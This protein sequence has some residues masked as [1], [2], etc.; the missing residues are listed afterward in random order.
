MVGGSE[1]VNQLCTDF[2]NDTLRAVG[3]DAPEKAIIANAAGWARIRFEQESQARE[4][5]EAWPLLTSRF[6]PGIQIIQTLHEMKGTLPEALDEGFEALRAARNLNRVE[7]PE[8]GPLVERSQRTG[9]AAVKVEKERDVKVLVDRST[10]RKRVCAAGHSSLVQKISQ[11]INK[12]AWPYEIDD[13][14]S[15]KSPYIAVI[16]AD[17]NDLGAT[18]MRIKEFLK[19]SPDDAAK[20]YRGFSAAI[21]ETTVAAVRDACEA[22]VFSAYRK[23]VEKNPK[24]KIAARPIVLGGDDL[25]IIIRADRA[26]E[27]TEKFLEAFEKSSKDILD[28]HLGFFKIEGRPEYLT[29]CA[30]IAFVKK[31][32][33]FSAAYHMAETLC[34][35]TKRVAKAARHEAGGTY[36]PSS[37][38]FHRITTSMAESFSTVKRQELTGRGLVGAEPVKFWFGPYGVGDH[39]GKL[40]K[41]TSLAG[42]ADALA[43]LPQGT[44]RTLIGTLHANPENAD[45]EYRRI[46]QV[47]GKDKGD[48]LKRA[49]SVL[50]SEEGHTLWNAGFHTPLTDAHILREI[51]KGGADVDAQAEI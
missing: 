14:V 28:K 48:N 40:P 5:F 27:F 43:E 16:H 29:A 18:L 13:I 39:G 42:L 23:A 3:V 36:V 24:A 31:A 2:L 22:T 12:D 30:G 45:K 1:L 4:F 46:L 7:L 6:A 44:I 8:I 49:L 35:H 25:T 34:D 19:A 33:P 50:T 10:V 37:F 51:A 11:E 38:T 41:L 47:A 21:E 15:G 17:G 26:V 9:G 20:I 32:Y